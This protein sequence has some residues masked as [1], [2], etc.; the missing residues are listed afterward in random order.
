[1]AQEL[2]SLVRVALDQQLSDEQS[3]RLQRLLSE[4]PAACDRYV[5]YVTLHAMLQ[6]EHA[7]PLEAVGSSKNDQPC[8]DD[9]TAVAERGEHSTVPTTPLPNPD[10]FV[11]VEDR[12]SLGHSLLSIHTPLGRMFLSCAV[13][14]LAIGT[15]TLSLWFWKWNDAVRRVAVNP[16]VPQSAP[17]Q[18]VTPFVGWISGRHDCQWAAESM[19]PVSEG[20]VQGQ[21]FS[22]AAGLVE[23]TYCTGAKVI[24]QGPV[25]YQVESKDGGYLSVG[26]LTARLEKRAGDLPHA[27][28]TPGAPFSVRTPTAVVTDLGTEFGVEV[29][30]EG[31]TTSHVFRGMIMLQAVSASGKVEGTNCVLRENET[32]QLEKSEVDEENGYR[33]TVLDSPAKPIDFVREI[34]RDDSDSTAKMFDLVDVVAGGNGFSGKRDA[35][36]DPTTGRPSNAVEFGNPKIEALFPPGDGKYHPVKE[37]PFV[38][39]VFVPD[40]SDGPVQV[41][42]TGHGFTGFPKTTNQTAL[43]IRA[44]GDI[45]TVRWP[46]RVTLDGV[47]Y[48]SQ[49][50]GLLFLHPNKGLTFDL[51]AIRKANPGW[52][53]KKFLAVGGNVGESGSL[54]DLW[55][56]V[57]GKMQFRR[58]RISSHQ[59]GFAIAIPLPPDS[60]FLTLASTDGGNGLSSDWIMFGDPRLE[61]IEVNDRES[62]REANGKGGR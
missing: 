25:T 10:P 29:S 11:A 24:L 60:R 47:D 40:G 37:L 3:A 62:S 38:D 19:A 50:H 9:D 54:A 57:D 32:A 41:D 20:V 45:P 53:I 31:S 30:E 12:L 26:K 14:F 13:A 35:S 27:T 33:L 4:S 36:I 17:E 18:T 44:G 22:L 1:M 51:N 34:S 8:E 2:E 23:I 5:E 46:I 59:G 56:L 48:A 7:P 52:T 28:R 16:I 39:G 21:E 58:W 49:G 55:V 42:S 61:L 15:V 43:L 6:W